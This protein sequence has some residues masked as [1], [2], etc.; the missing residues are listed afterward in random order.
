M[1]YVE[2]H[3]SLRDH[4]KTKKVARLLNIPKVQ[5]IGHLLCLWWW[6]QDYAQDGSLGAYDDAD[7]AEAAEWPGDASAFVNALLNCGPKGSAGFLYRGEDG[8]LA[9]N[10]WF[11]YGGKLFVAREQSRIRM[12]NKRQRDAAVTRNASVTDSEV[13]HTFSDVTPIDQIRSDQIS[14]PPD[15]VIEDLAHPRPK[16]KMWPN[17]PPPPPYQPQLTNPN[18]AAP[19]ASRPPSR[20]C[21]A[22]WRPCA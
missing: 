1:A 12:R 3:A 10:D 6:C 2:A 20:R 19:R 9:I 21:L 15:G 4:L 11:E 16:R 22:R 8:N 7:I 18:P 17:C 13:T 14:I 5:V